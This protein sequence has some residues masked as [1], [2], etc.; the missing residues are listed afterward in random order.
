MRLVFALLLLCP[1]VVSP[2]QK[3]ATAR[4]SPA[5]KKEEP[6][7]K[8][9]SWPI[10]S[11]RVE[12]NRIHSQ[13]AILAASGLKVGQAV[14]EHAFEEAQKRLEA[15]GFFESVGFHYT[16]SADG[17]GYD[18]SFQVVEVQQAYPV[19]FER[20]P[21]S[22]EELKKALTLADPLFSEK[23]PGTKPVLQR[24][25]K[26]LTDYLAK[27]D[28]KDT[29]IGRVSPEGPGGELYV[30][31]QP[32]TVLPA[33]AEVTFTGNKVI[34]TAALQNAIA[35]AAVGATYL[36]PRFRQILDAN[37]RPLYETRGRIRVAFPK[38]E[39][40][41]VKDV[42]GL[43]V[44]VTVDE[45]PTYDLGEVTIVD[46]VVPVA[47]LRKAANL[48]SGDLANFTE[49]NAGIERMRQVVR[50]QG[51]LMA[52]VTSE[53]HPNDEKK[54]VDLTIRTDPGERFTFGKLELK[55]LDI[56]SEPVVRRLW[57]IKPGQPFNP[58]Y[59]DF[60]LGRIREDG[61]FDNLGKTRSAIQVD[62]KNRTVDVTLYFR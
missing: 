38:I 20:L 5:A 45:G 2:Q 6:A 25:Q 24:Y 36:E 60:F 48:K 35:G 8:Q 52:K 29:V 56:L 15:T 9:E 46:T 61:V 50:R 57:T 51:F 34:P 7:P 41:P 37:I 49:I 13:E 40:E 11:L 14:S 58:E 53:R 43:R 17:K 4:K 12:G 39:T 47:E 31:F 26:L 19:R 10:A 42:S 44:T 16:P 27:R 21:G 59:P 3:K 32:A 18:G 1:I 62:E 23:I 33:I 30:I 54:I 28:F 22:L 55:G